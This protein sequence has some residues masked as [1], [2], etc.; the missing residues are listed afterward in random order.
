MY[1]S[2]NEDLC[3]CINRLGEQPILLDVYYYPPSKRRFENKV[4]I[5][6]ALENLK[7][8]HKGYLCP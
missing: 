2:A 4:A 7:L 8:W 5:G 1:C 6:L 3:Q